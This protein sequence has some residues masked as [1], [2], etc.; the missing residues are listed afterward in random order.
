VPHPTALAL[1]ETGTDLDVYEADAGQ[2]APFLLTEFGISVPAIVVSESPLP[3][4]DIFVVKGPGFTTG[5]DLVS[6]ARPADVRLNGK[7]GELLPPVPDVPREG[8]SEGV[9]V[10]LSSVDTGAASSEAPPAEGGAPSG[11]ASGGGDEKKPE[12][13]AGSDTEGER[14]LSDFALGVE[15]ALRQRRPEG[16][17]GNLQGAA[18]A[19]GRDL[20]AGTAD[21]EPLSL[22]AAA[23]G[24][25]NAAGALLE[26]CKPLRALP[27]ILASPLL[28]EG[29]ERLLRALPVTPEPEEGPPKTEENPDR[30]TPGPEAD[31]HPV[32]DGG[33]S[34]TVLLKVAVVAASG[35]SWRSRHRA[36]RRRRPAIGK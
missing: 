29:V 36:K 31:A 6:P 11:A 5:L 24:L 9:A 8:M 4:A 22:R 3:L 32:S 23:E 34:E 2:E 12:P 14:D 30:N 19:G 25:R 33:R 1:A 17:G 13:G 7:E 18:H 21:K 16:L 20:A 27:R 28:A 35:L 26:T 10:P 15:E